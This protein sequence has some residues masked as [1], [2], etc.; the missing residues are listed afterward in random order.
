MYAYDVLQ[1]MNYC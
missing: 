1:R